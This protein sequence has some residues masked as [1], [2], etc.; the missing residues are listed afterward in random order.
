MRVS[1]TKTAQRVERN[2]YRTTW[3]IKS[4]GK[5]N[6]YPQKVLEILNSSGTGLTCFDIYTKFIAGSGFKDKTLAETFLNPKERGNS[7]LKKCG[8]DLKAFKGFALLIKYN[9]MLDKSIYNIPFEHLRQEVD[10]LKHLTGRLAYH[11]DWTGIN[12]LT[13]KV[14]DIKYLNTYNIETVRT[15]IKE[16]K[17]PKNYLGQVYYFTSD[18]DF[19]YPICPFDP[20]ITDMLT[21]ESCSTV[22]HR[23]AKYNFLP[24]G[25][26]V[27]KGIKPRLDDEGAIDK[28]NAYNQEQ[29]E[30]RDEIKRMQGD[31]N[32]CKMWVVDIDA[33]EEKPEFVPFNTRSLDK[34]YTYTESSV[35]ANINSMFLI[36][37]ILRGKDVGYGFSSDKMQEAYSFMNS[38]V[39]EERMS[40]TDVFKTILEGKFDTTIDPLIYIAT[41][42][43]SDKNKANDSPDNEGGK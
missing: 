28:R 6:D 36:P 42:E 9:G 11:P 43:V 33:D 8:K 16:V 18:G 34:E 22:K 31:E 27:R 35:Q 23:N 32:A 5:D 13:F 12:G 1:G 30:S 39:S 15:E 38:I 24:G 20:I 14:E 3:K 21:E 10:E 29:E 41:Q 40:I 26:I 17:G 7:I 37:P 25:I 4:Y 2:Q 19:E